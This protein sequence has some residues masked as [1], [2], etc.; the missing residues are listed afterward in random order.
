MP[1]FRTGCS[2][3][4]L[5]RVFGVLPSAALALGVSRSWTSYSA[6]SKSELGRY[7]APQARGGRSR[8]SAVWGAMPINRPEGQSPFHEAWEW[9]GTAKREYTSISSLNVAGTYAVVA[10]CETAIR[11]LY[12][13]ATDE[14]FPYEVFKSEE[15]NPAALVRAVG[16]FE[17]YTPTMRQFLLKYEGAN[18]AEVRYERTQ[19]YRDHRKPKAAGR[20]KEL[21]AGGEQSVRETEAPA[22]RP[23]VLQA[24]RAHRRK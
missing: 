7:P 20:A 16:T 13:V 21:V 1:V 9:I 14:P 19:A 2:Y 17:F 10:G 11:N 24:V 22:A 12:E 23:D 4:D 6:R 8:T 3:L 15:H 5:A 18:L